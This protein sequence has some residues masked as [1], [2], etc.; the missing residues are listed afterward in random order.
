MIITRPIEGQVLR[1]PLPPA[2]AN[3]PGISRLCISGLA[4][5]PHAAAEEP[6]KIVEKIL[7]RLKL[8]AGCCMQNNRGSLLDLSF[9]RVYAGEGVNQKNYT[10]LHGNDVQGNTRSPT[11]SL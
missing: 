1:A 11:R 10:H 3:A 6:E 9:S 2:S 5:G 8:Q 7:A 4:C